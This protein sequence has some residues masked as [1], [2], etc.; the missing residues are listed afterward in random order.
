MR[1]ALNVLAWLGLV[2]CL[3]WGMSLTGQRNAISHDWKEAQRKNDVLQT[4]YHQAQ[5]ETKEAQAAL[6]KQKT[7]TEALRQE[8]VELSDALNK[9]KKTAEEKQ[10]RA[11]EL[12][13]QLE[14]ARQTV[15]EAKGALLQA[16]AEWDDRLRVLT[17]EKETAQNRL[18]EVM[19]VLL[20]PT[21]APEAEPAE[22]TPAPDSLEDAFG[23]P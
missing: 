22:E 18:A 21:E 4:L 11:A 2:V 15:M 8:S 5:E 23:A 6:E 19:S 13:Q 9:A 12:E 16:Q 3:I 7:E 1:K 14:A 20:P 17:E 10:Q